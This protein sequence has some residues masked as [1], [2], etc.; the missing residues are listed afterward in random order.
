MKASPAQSFDEW[1]AIF[2][3]GLRDLSDKTVEST[4]QV[5]AGVVG[6]NLAGER[7][8]LD[9]QIQELVGWGEPGAVGFPAELVAADQK[10]AA[11]KEE[12][13]DYDGAVSAVR[14]VMRRVGAK[15]RLY[16]GKTD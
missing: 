15:H 7:G 9:K 4:K 1:F 10:V 2:T 8:A 5:S 12:D 13:R 11:P 3:K 6:K 16:P 14:D